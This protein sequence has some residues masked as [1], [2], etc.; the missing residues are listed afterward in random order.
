MK[1]ITIILFALVLLTGCFCVGRCEDSFIHPST[2]SFRNDKIVLVAPKS[3]PIFQGM[4]I[5]CNIHLWIC[6]W[7]CPNGYE[8]AK[9]LKGD[10]QISKAVGCSSGIITGPS[11]SYWPYGNYVIPNGL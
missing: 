3:E 10:Q 8:Y 9:S 4:E 1:I 2:D 6:Y 7:T 11:K 5:E